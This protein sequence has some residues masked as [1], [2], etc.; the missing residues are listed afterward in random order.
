MKMEQTQCSETSAIKHHTP[1]NNPKGYTRQDDHYYG[2]KSGV[3]LGTGNV[4]WLKKKTLPLFVPVIETS[5]FLVIDL[6]KCYNGPEPSRRRR[7]DV[8][9]RN[10]Y[11]GYWGLSQGRNYGAAVSGRRIQGPA[12]LML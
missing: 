8:E 11:A 4:S 12:K 9:L 2:E 3:V 10:R 5:P 1:E 7:G 6:K